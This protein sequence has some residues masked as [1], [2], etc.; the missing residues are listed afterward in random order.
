MTTITPTFWAQ[1]QRPSSEIA[2]QLATFISG[3]KKS[4]DIAIYDFDLKDADQKRVVDAI[5]AVAARGARVRIAYDHTKQTDTAEGKGGTGNDPA[6]RGTQAFVQ[7]NFPESTR[8][9]TQAIAGSHLMHSKYVVRDGVDI[10][11]GSANFTEDAWFEQDNNVVEII[12]A[13]N[14]ANHYETDFAQLWATKDIKGTGKND[15][16]NVQVAGVEVEFAFSP[17]EGSAVASLFVDAI[18]GAKGQDVQ[19]ATMVLSSGPILG[20]LVDHLREGGTISGVYDESQMR[21]VEKDW[22]AHPDTSKTKLDQWNAVKKFL[23]GKP[24]KSYSAGGRNFMHNKVLVTKNTVITG[25][26]NLSRNAES[27]AENA[28]A[29]HDVKLAG[30]YQKYV[31]ALVVKYTKHQ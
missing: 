27:N 6:P 25:S 17:G 9:H 23:V 14:L 20:A 22:G 11:M 8:V 2:A 4:L 7:A 12:D 5:K 28:L 15:Y 1:G 18:Q 3:T 30:E 26:F 13:K 24:S 16:G 29:F 31:K 10:W 19:V 21:Q